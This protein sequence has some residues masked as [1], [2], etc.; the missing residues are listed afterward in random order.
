MKKIMAALVITAFMV[1]CQTVLANG[2][3][4]LAWEDLIPSDSPAG[5]PFEGLNEDQRGAA[6]W[7]LSV[8]DSLP[9]RNADNE[10]IFKV[11]DKALAELKNAGI[12]IETI[13][14]KSK[15]L[16]SSV[17]DELN[18]QTIRLPGYLLPLEMSG[19]DVTEFLLVPYVGAC[20]HAPPPPP[21]QIVHVTID[22]EKGYKSK[23]LF[24]PV[25]VTGVISIKTLV[26]DLYLVDGSD[27][28][29]IGYIMQ[30]STV[31]PYEE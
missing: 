10:E 17:V 19:T 18:G 13:R 5:D 11:I 23:A 12:D 29:T 4:T 28:I 31:K 9:E 26:K 27:D 14:E 6:A 16:N 20:I 2:I 22:G 7:T 8:L 30:A 1:T 3:Q 21:N 24:D 25:L 15:I